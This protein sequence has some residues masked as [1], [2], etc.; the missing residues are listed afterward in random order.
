MTIKPETPYGFCPVCGAAGR[1]RERRPFGNDE[2]ENGHTY[3]SAKSLSHKPH[4]PPQP[5]I[6][7]AMDALTTHERYGCSE[8]GCQLL[9]DL[10]DVSYDSVDASL[11]LIRKFEQATHDKAHEAGVAQGR[12]GTVLGLTEREWLLSEKTTLTALIEDTPDSDVFGGMSL[13]SRLEQVEEELAALPPQG[14]KK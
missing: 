13:K 4:T 2:C 3:P 14:G 12:K 1:M 8:A 5:D 6:E 11:D 10:C 7:D 9:K